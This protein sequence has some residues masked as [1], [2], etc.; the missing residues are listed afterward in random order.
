MFKLLKHAK[1]YIA[2][3]ILSPVLMIGEVVLELLIP[4]VMAEIVNLVQAGM[5]EESVNIILRLGL[6]MLTFLWCY[7]C[8]NGC[9]GRYGLWCSIE[10]RNYGQNSEILIFKY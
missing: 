7:G 4:L 1:K 6:K 8:K 3:T 10:R 9:C 5:T 2:P